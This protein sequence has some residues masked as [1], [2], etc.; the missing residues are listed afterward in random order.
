MLGMKK[1]SERHIDGCRARWTRI[2]LPLKSSHPMRSF[3][4]TFFNNMVFLRAYFFVHR[5]RVI[6]GKDGSPLN[7]VRVLCNSMLENK[8]IMMA[9][10][11]IR[12]NPEKSVLKHRPGDEIRL[13]QGDFLKLSKATTIA[14]RKRKVL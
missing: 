2:V 6:A 5:L 9:D 7:E 14:I 13:K 1:Y 10:K 11:A 12:L 8:N 3:E 4:V